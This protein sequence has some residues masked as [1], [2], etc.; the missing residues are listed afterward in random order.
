MGQRLFEAVRRP[1]GR[2]PH[3]PYQVLNPAH[4]PVQTGY[5]ARDGDIFDANL[6]R[7]P[8]GRL[9]SLT[10]Q[11]PLDHLG[12]GARL[13]SDS[14]ITNSKPLC[15]TSPTRCSFNETGMKICDLRRTTPPRLQRDGL[16]ARSELIRAAE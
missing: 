2:H 3:V 6:V 16:A 7:A 9:R 4:R 14:Q 11:W 5:A 15:S 12:C 10:R 1:D 8:P 13:G